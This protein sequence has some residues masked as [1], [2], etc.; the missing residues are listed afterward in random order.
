MT[1]MYYK[2]FGPSPRPINDKRRA[3]GQS[4]STHSPSS[5]VANGCFN[6]ANVTF[7]KDCKN[8]LV[9]ETIKLST[10]FGL[11]ITFLLFNQLFLITEYYGWGCY[12]INY[13]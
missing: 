10:L 6:V 13:M 3:L 2:T 5:H 9:L 12:V 11:I 7:I 4:C 8:L 1:N